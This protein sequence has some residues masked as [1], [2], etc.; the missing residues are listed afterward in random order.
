M[1]QQ[2]D[3]ARAS[4]TYFSPEGVEG[5]GPIKDGDQYAK[6]IESAK[7]AKA[8]DDYMNNETEEVDLETALT[9]L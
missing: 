2:S 7:I 3:Q 1:S 8:V 5:V 4:V 6:N 9:S